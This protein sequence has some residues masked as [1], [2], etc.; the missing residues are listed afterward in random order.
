V[1]PAD[2][3]RGPIEAVDLEVRYAETDAMGVVHHANY[4][5]WFELARTALCQRSGFHYAEIER[6]G[7]FLM[8]TGAELRYRQGARYGDTVR[9]RC[10][11]AHLGSRGLR[12]AYTVHRGKDLLA[13]GATDHVWVD[14]ATG[15]P[16]RTPEILREPFARLAGQLA[17]EDAPRP[18]A[19]R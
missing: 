5:V 13:D 14:R 18:E 16:C 1:S 6:R 4:L 17:A 2:I 10:W 19:E 9:V 11:V 12:F 15:R 8:V 7:T 3:P